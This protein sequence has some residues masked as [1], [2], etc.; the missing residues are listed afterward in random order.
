MLEAWAAKKPFFIRRTG[1][2]AEHPDAAF[3][4]SKEDSPA[5]VA[6][7]IEEVVNNINAENNARIIENA[8]NYFRTM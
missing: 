3:I 1:I 4:Y 6:R 5:S 8:Y 2:A 7:Y